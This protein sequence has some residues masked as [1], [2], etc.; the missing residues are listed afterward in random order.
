MK[1]VI[2]VV[3][4]EESIR[5]ML[6]MLLELQG[7]E[8]LQAEDGMDALDKLQQADPDAIILDVM[9]PK[10]D[11]ITFC[12]IVREDVATASLPIIMLSGKTQFGAAEEGLAAG[13]NFYM[14]KPMDSQE[15]LAKI[16][17]V[18]SQQMVSV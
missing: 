4:D 6:A 12:K 2:L 17:H 18:L 7:F 10:M 1:P 9:M 5:F 15:L 16:R 3:D 13:A 11:G 8:V 14:N